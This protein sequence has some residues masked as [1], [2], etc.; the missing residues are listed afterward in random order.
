MR[1]FSKRHFFVTTA[2]PYANGTF[3]I[4]HM[5]EYIQA[6]IWVRFQRMLGHEVHFICADD[7]HGAAIMIAAEN[8]G[9]TPKKFVDNI[10]AGRKQYLDGFYIAFDN[11]H[12]TDSLENHILS[13]EIYCTLRDDAK[14]IISKNVN[15]FFDLVKN[16][17]LPDR[18]IKGECPICYT[19]DQ[20]GDVCINCSS[21]Y[22]PTCLK[23]PYSIL[24]GSRPVIKSS[25]HFFF[26]LSDT[27]C[28]KFLRQWI[29]NENR[30]QPE[31][32][33]KIKEWI[34][35]KN[36]NLSDW[37]ISRD[38]PYFGINIPDE[39]GKYFYVWLDA[40]IG[41]LASLKNYFDKIGHDFESFITDEKTEQYHFIGKDIMYFHILFWPA[42]L[43]FSGRKIP[44]NIFVHGFITIHGKKMSKSSNIGI[45]PL[46][47]LNIG[48]NPEWLRYY[49]AT[50]LNATIKDIDF[51]QTDFINRVNADLIGKYVN[52]ASRSAGFI[53]KKFANTIFF[54]QNINYNPLLINLRNSAK[55]IA[56]FYDSR[57]YGKA[58]CLIMCHADEIN[59][60]IDI[61][62]PW[63]LAKNS[64]KHMT[65]HFICSILL[66]FFRILTIYLKPVL[67]KLAI[68]VENF[69]KITPL[70]WDDIN[71][72]LQNGHKINTY[73]HLMHRVDK[74]L[75]HELFK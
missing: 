24:S 41:Y 43:K 47:Y 2:L 55:N 51:D 70:V 65:L 60:F 12:S 16:I 26:K 73:T 64:E 39:P 9:V 74:N 53:T 52:I 62:K 57:E 30:L 31:V 72:T 5:M 18:Y 63:I 68:Q 7:V 54:N 19:K 8:A 69:L 27:R 15:Q 46:H 50:K 36:N 40:P 44:T 22:D 23:N 75:L 42:L 58:L 11:W 38:A 25:K 1:T 34:N 66:E 3:H 21:V 10:T 67:P 28:V 17:Y 48:M 32:I 13:K 61:Q 71:H 29:F 37:D 6:D 20:Y 56:N 45:S 49:I 33:N 4:G 14:L 59:T 35:I